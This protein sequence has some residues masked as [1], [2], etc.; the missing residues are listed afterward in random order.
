MGARLTDSA[1]Y[2]HLWGTDEL[3]RV[4]DEAGRIQGWLDVL[5][6]L[7]Q[8]QAELGIIPEE[9]AKAIAGSSSVELLDLE[10]VAEETRRTGHS[11]L[12]L[13]RGWQAVLPDEAREWVYYGATV[14]D[15]T[16]TWSAL[17]ARKVLGVAWRDLRAIEEIL[18][19]LAEAHRDTLRAGRTHGQPGSPI[20]FGYKAAGWA[21]EVRR[22]LDRLREA[23]P[24]LFAGQLGGG[25]GTLAFFGSGGVELRRRFCGLLGLET[26]AISWTS[27]RDRPAE[28]VHL[29]AM[30]TATLAR[31]GNEV[32]Q[33]S[34]P[35][36]GELAETP[37]PGVVGSITMPHK[38]NPEIAE[39]LV[40]LSRLVRAQQ[41]VVLEG[42][43]A[44]GERDGRGWKAEWAAVPEACLLAGA[45][46]DLAKRMLA[47]LEVR[48]EAMRG[49]LG[50]MAASEKLLAALAP[51]KGK[52]ATQDVLQRALAAGGSLEEAASAAGLNGS[53]LLAPDAGAAGAMVD[54]VVRRARAARASEP[55]VWP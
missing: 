1:L 55:E 10:A 27:S 52:H 45:A 4:F 2:A 26:P 19:S 20:T 46:L 38:R 39:H 16:D 36:I 13:I 47:G 37:G 11:T 49:N 24:R 12:G 50:A 51:S 35:E 22:H 43:V 29:L 5:A 31:V 8:A 9:A 30:V 42:M 17:A 28:L 7:A 34:R 53:D 54:E 23:G 18:L 15:L 25:V 32:Y 21:D 48:P 40:T 14:Q 44:E 3:R 6:A 33:L 41:G